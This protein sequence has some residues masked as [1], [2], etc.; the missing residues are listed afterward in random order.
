VTPKPL[1]RMEALIEALHPAAVAQ[2]ERAWRA[3][4]ADRWIPVAPLPGSPTAPPLT[5]PAVVIA[6]WLAANDAFYPERERLL[7]ST[8]GRRMIEKLAEAAG[9]LT[10]SYETDA[11]ADLSDALILSAFLLTVS[12]SRPFPEPADW[13]KLA[14]ALV[15][16]YRS[17]QHGTVTLPLAA[18]TVPLETIAEHV[19][20][21]QT[22]A[23][24]A[25]GYIVSDSDP[26]GEKA[27]DQLVR[28]LARLDTLL[29]ALGAPG[30]S[31]ATHPDVPE[32]LS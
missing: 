7:E 20:Q 28:S 1:T 16:A 32:V 3:A 5:A 26:D 4:P 27:T 9:G 24:A 12:G 15:V 13:A 11:A 21:A 2:V 29:A 8:P 23:R 18:I 25:L 31:P 17:E 19:E 14:L 22:D 10:T 30:L 6:E